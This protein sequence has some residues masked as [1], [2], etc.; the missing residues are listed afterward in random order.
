MKCWWYDIALEQRRNELSRGLTTIGT[1][2]FER[3]GCYDCDGSPKRG[4][5]P[6]YEEQRELYGLQEG[7]RRLVL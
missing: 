1:I 4:A 6:I 5:C 7:R 3:Q 2:E